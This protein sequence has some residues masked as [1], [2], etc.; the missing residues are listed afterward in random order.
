MPAPLFW[1]FVLIMLFFGGMVVVNRSPVAS[2]MSLVVCFLGLA[3][4]YI[5]LDA[6]FLGVI[7]ILV[8][9]GAVMVL[10]L[11]IIMLLDLKAEQR[12]HFNL[13]AMFGGLVVVVLFVKVLF[14]VCYGFQGGNAVFPAITHNAEHGDTW[15][16][17]MALFQ[18]YKLP[19]QI[20]G[21]LIVVASVGAVLLSKREL[22]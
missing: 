15:Q 3:A 17:G 19:L 13:I 14:D 5:S 22:K 4:L 21:A 2:A 1:I 20:I 12:R 8:Y 18:Q 16:V 6:F 7:Q 10:F 9:A 11:F